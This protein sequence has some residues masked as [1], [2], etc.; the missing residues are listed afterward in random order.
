ML[1]TGLHLTTQDYEGVESRRPGVRSETGLFSTNGL[2]DE[3]V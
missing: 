1:L 3:G 2:D